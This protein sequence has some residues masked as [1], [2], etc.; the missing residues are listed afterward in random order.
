MLI[1]FGLMQVHSILK[2]ALKF[3]GLFILKIYSNIHL[4]LI[5]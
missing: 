2:S 4:L 5:Y 1:E 3:K